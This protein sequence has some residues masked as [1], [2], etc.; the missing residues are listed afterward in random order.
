MDLN[1][2]GW[3]NGV[4]DHNLFTAGHAV[5][6]QI[7][8]GDPAWNNETNGQGNKSWADSSYWGSSKFLFIE[9]NQF[10]Q[11]SGLSYDEAFDCNNGGRFVFRY[12]TV[13]YH[14]ALQTHAEENDWR[15]CRAMELYNN[16]FTYS[17]DSKN[18]NFAF[19]LMLESG[20]GLAWGNTITGFMQF[21]HEDVVRTNNATYTQTATPNGWGYCSSSPIGGVPGPSPWDQNTPGQNGYACIDQVGRGKGDLLTGVFPNKVNSATGTIAWPNQVLDPWYVWHNTYNPV[22]QEPDPLLDELRFRDR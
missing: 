7:R 16:T 11:A 6:N 1:I 15:P 4:V 21:I 2:Q 22:P 8:V 10:Y 17:S 19:L 5:E 9:A 13:G 12:N 14:T 18:D 3:I 20:A